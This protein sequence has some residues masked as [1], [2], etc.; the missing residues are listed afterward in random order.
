VRHLV[1]LSAPRTGSHML[2]SMLRADASIVDLGA[3]APPWECLVEPPRVEGLRAFYQAHMQRVAPLT[4]LSNWHLLGGVR[5]VADIVATGGVFI[6]LYRRDLLAQAAS[7]KLAREHGCYY[8]AAPP[9]A[10][11]TLGQ[12]TRDLMDN[13]TR[14]HEQLQRILPGLPHRTLA[15]E[16]I[17][18]PTV[19]EI[20]A[21]LL[22]RAVVVGAPT[23]PK[24]APAL[25][26]YVT[27]LSEFEP[28][29]LSP[30]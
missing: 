27:N 28:R 16:D 22:G 11:V 20:A 9:G 6:Y 7:A 1:I 29:K 17:T 23:T 8:K 3:L 30:N 18:V 25:E 19:A 10:K 14:Q 2:R 21:E 26:T 12:D 5:G 4:V 13:W 24:S 15:Y